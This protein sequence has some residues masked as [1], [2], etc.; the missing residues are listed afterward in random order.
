MI[1]KQKQT[2]SFCEKIGMIKRN[3]KNY[4]KQNS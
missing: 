3:D 1:K 4:E 2:G